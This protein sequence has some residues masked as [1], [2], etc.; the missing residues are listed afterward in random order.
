MIDWDVGPFR[1]S[2]VNAE[3]AWWASGLTCS[4]K[5]STAPVKSQSVGLRHA[6]RPACG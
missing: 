5:A 4:Q 3:W 2:S 1:P 6:V